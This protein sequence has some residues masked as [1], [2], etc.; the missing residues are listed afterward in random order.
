[1]YNQ[2]HLREDPY[3][4][5][6]STTN[7]GSDDTPP[8]LSMSYTYTPVHGGP[9]QGEEGHKD[10]LTGVSSDVPTTL[11]YVTPVCVSVR[12]TK[13]HVTREPGLKKHT[14]PVGDEVLT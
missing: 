10:M 1:M 14:S 2:G 12:Y 9:L 4:I 13:H 7:A 8:S 3:T 11:Q 6:I 5:T